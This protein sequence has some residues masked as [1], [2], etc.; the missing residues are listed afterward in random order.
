MGGIDA[1]SLGLE[2]KPAIA[3]AASATG[4]RPASAVAR[5]G[6]EHP[7]GF[8]YAGTIPG[9]W[10]PGSLPTVAIYEET[11]F[12]I[13]AVYFLLHPMTSANGAGILQMLAALARFPVPHN[14][15]T[16]TENPANG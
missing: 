7:I 11:L 16:V 9:L 2:L 14:A 3:A 12:A 5:V 10:L 8:C 15:Y 6:R 4:K 13:V 1:P